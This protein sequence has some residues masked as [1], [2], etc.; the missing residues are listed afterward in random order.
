[1]PPTPSATS[2]P[3]A[4]SETSAARGSLRS[5]SPAGSPK[6]S[7]TCSPPTSPSPRPLPEAPL[8]VWPLDGPFGL[9]P[10]QPASHPARSS[11][12]GGNTDMSAA[13]PTTRH[14]AG[15]PTQTAYRQ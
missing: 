5:I 3:S 12:R 9:A 1:T 7:G 15:G 4:G 11:R 13:P 10:T 8:F 14:S 2:T 6:P